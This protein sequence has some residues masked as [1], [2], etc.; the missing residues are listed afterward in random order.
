MGQ[1]ATEG[2]AALIS[3]HSCLF[4]GRNAHSKAIQPLF[5]MMA[6]LEPEE[7]FVYFLYLFPFLFLFPFAFPFLFTPLLF[8]SIAL[9][10]LHLPI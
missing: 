7:G 6:K 3:L 5:I 2:K 10:V 1:E 8:S 9:L 4:S